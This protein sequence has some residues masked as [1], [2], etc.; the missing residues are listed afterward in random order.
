MNAHELSKDVLEQLECPVC[1]E[2]MQPPITLCGNGHSICSSCKQKL[3]KCPT[4]RKPF[5]PIRN[6]TLEKLAVRVQCPCP[7]EPYGCTLT[8]PIAL[9]HKHQDVCRYSPTVCPIRKLVHCEWKG[10]FEEVRHHVTEKHRNWVTNMSG[11]TEVLIK[12]FNRNKVY[13]RIIL[14]NDDIFQQRFE[15][16]GSAVYYVIK[17]IGRDERASQFK[18]KFKLGKRSDKI[19]V[20]KIVSR[21]NVDVREVYNTGKCVKLYYDTIERFLGQENNLKFSFKISKV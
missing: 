1:T 18:Y 19:S 15:V 3:Q 7:N 11:M 16:L 12:N 10:S 17:Y 13:V 14:L 5:S 8:F 21:Y 9:L 4:C 2:Y 20:C 6:R